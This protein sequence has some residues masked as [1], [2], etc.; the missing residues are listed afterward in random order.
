[1]AVRN[2]DERVLLKWV[3]S[4]PAKLFGGIAIWKLLVEEKKPK[5]TG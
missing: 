2:N 5:P 1:M 4:W 3:P